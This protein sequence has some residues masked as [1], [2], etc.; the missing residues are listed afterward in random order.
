MVANEK[1]YHNPK[2]KIR[3]IILTV[4]IPLL[5]ISI[6]LVGIM[7]PVLGNFMRLPEHAVNNA[8]HYIEPKARIFPGH[9][10]IIVPKKKQQEVN[11]K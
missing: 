4:S 3:L 2:R 8:K 11:I 9:S 1:H 10:S 7:N 6:L 5:L